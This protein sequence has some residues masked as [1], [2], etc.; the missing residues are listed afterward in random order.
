MTK[1]KIHLRFKTRKSNDLNY[2]LVSNFI[3]APLHEYADRFV[4][5]T[6]DLDERSCPMVGED[7]RNN[8]AD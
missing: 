1:K 2:E 7:F 6:N 8:L 4:D 5:D 3:N